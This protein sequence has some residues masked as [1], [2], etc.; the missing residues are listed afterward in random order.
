MPARLEDPRRARSESR[1]G[2]CC[3]GRRQPRRA[4]GLGCPRWTRTWPRGLAVDGRRESSADYGLPVRQ[5]SHALWGTERECSGIFSTAYLMFTK[6]LQPRS[7]LD[8]DLFGGGDIGLDAESGL[9]PDGCFEG[10]HN[11]VRPPGYPK[12]S[13]LTVS[14]VLV[15]SLAWR[16]ETNA[17]HTNF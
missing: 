13:V 15:F 9:R 2:C 4:V 10:V 1:G 12:P 16:M 6:A 14:D 11:A 3:I 17:A 8:P 5:L 7:A